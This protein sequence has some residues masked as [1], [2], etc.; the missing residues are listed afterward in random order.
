MNN[1]G[2]HFCIICL[3]FSLNLTSIEA[4]VVPGTVSPTQSAEDRSSSTDG[5]D[6]KL[7][8]TTTKYNLTLG[9]AS[10]SGVFYPVGKGISQMVNKRNLDYGLKFITYSTSGSRYNLQAIR[11]G[12]LDFAISR[13]DLAYDAYR[14][15]GNFDKQEPFTELRYIATLYSMPIGVIVHKKSPIQ[16]LKDLKGKRVNIGNPGSGKRSV[17]NMI[18]KSMNWKN[19]DFER[20]TGLATRE[21]GDVF[22]NRG[23]DA[24]I[25]LLGIPASFYDK[26]TQECQG[27]FIPIPSKIVL[28]IQRENPF[29]DFADIP[30]GLYPNNLQN[31]TTFQIGAVLLT[32]RRLSGDIVFQVC[33]TIF[34]NMDEFRKIHPA[35]IFFNLNN[36]KKKNTFIPYHNGALK[37]YRKQGIT[38]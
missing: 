30:G 5:L 21:M 27:R 34:D 25:E 38:M 19:S 22:C 17:A 35:L 29:V 8:N 4:K 3:F 9:T 31:I 2:K 11:N 26:I 18:F 32:S 14:G 1:F 20:V 10:E 13:F 6:T 15:V 28:S 16:E 24:I 33:Q 7:I 37:Y 23:I 12:E 36:I